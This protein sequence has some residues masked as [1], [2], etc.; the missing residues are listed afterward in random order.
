MESRASKTVLEDKNSRNSESTFSGL[1]PLTTHDRA[2]VDSRH[3]NTYGDGFD[4]VGDEGEKPE[5]GDVR[6]E[7]VDDSG[8]V[9]NPQVAGMLNDSRGS[10][11]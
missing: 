6:T 11:F 4:F 3:C 2:S 7:G 5:G 9:S 1:E 8:F 10:F